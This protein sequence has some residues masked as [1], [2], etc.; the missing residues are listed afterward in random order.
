METKPLHGPLSTL[1]SLSLSLLLL[2][3]LVQLCHQ[4]L[5]LPLP[6]AQLLPSSRPLG[7]VSHNCCFLFAKRFSRANTHRHTN[8]AYVH[9]GTN[10][11]FIYS[12]LGFPEL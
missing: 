8:T 3:L 6:S 10:T 9:A 5:P 12:I 11:I 4:P 2:L 7:P 1:V